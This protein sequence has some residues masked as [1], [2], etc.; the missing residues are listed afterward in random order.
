[1]DVVASST[2]SLLGVT[3]ATLP[4]V[5]QSGLTIESQIGYTGV[6]PFLIGMPLESVEAVTGAPWF[7]LTCGENFVMPLESGLRQGDVSFSTDVNRRVTG[8][9][10][11][12]PLMRTISG[13]HVGSTEADV[14]RTYGNVERKAYGN[15]TSTLVITNPEGRQVN[16]WVSKGVVTQMLVAESAQSIV[17][18]GQC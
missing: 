15:D 9:S 13:I 14:M 4:P 3:P 17:D 5:R 1:M 18:Q 2:V 11:M 10:V 6:G 12:S 8:I 16:F 7:F